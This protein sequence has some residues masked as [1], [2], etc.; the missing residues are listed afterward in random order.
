MAEWEAV[1]GI[2]THVELQTKSKMFCGCAVA[3]GEAP[4]T[5]TCPVCLALPGAIPVPNEE[6]IEGIVKIGTALDSTINRDSLFYRKNYFYPDL[7]K[8]YQISQY[9]FPVCEFGRLEIM[10]DDEPFTVGITRVHMEEDTGKSRHVGEDGRIYDASHSLLD[11][12]R[13]G[14]PLVEIVTEPDIRTAEQARAY[15]AEL[16]RIVRT[17]GVSDARLEEGSMRFD[18]NVSVRRGPD[19]E[20]G[21]RTETKNVNSLRSLQRA[22]TFEIDRQIRVLEEGG[23]I[24]QETR[25]WNEDKGVTISMR[26]KEESED[27][28]YFQE[29]DM[30]PLEIDEAWQ[31]RVKAEQPELPAQKRARYAGLG[32]D[33]HTAELLADDPDL[34]GLFDQSVAAGANAKQAGIWI[35]QEVVA[36]LRR[37]EKT[38]GETSLS[39]VHV[40]ELSEMVSA[41]DL[42][43][44]ASKDVL[45]AVLAGDGTPREIAKAKDLIQ[46]S[47]S[48]FLEAEVDAVIADNGDA[49]E[50]LVG[51]DMKMIGFFVGQVMKRTGGKADPRLVSEMVRDKAQG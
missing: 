7:P 49:F 22:I 32:T 29:P 6:A 47:D 24:I 45:N 42:S 35:T 28:R 31:Q 21:T 34:G 23:E 51:G 50:K 19:A 20:F 27:Y 11:F 33:A 8:N 40:A 39:A 43:S 36:Y 2:E 30:L 26:I 5:N 10:V 17:L 44:T 25:H 12:N 14:V 13:S 1:I 15:G 16:Q 4:N 38:L 9:T 18:A 48:G 41:G 37:E 3:F 46:I